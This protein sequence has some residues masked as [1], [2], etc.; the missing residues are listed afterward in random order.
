MLM[1]AHLCVTGKQAFEPTRLGH[2]RYSTFDQDETN[3][4][5]LVH[6]C[7]QLLKGQIFLVSCSDFLDL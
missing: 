6:V 5:V 2:Y 1:Q 7:Q 4:Y 3:M